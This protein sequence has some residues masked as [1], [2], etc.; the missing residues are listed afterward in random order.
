MT[1]SCIP[2]PEPVSN[3]Y[4]PLFA[5]P[6]HSLGFGVLGLGFRFIGLSKEETGVV[7]PFVLK[8]LLLG[9]FGGFEVE[10]FNGPTPYKGPITLHSQH[11]A[12]EP[13]VVNLSPPKSY[14]LV[15][16]AKSIPKPPTLNVDVMTLRSSSQ[17]PALRTLGFATLN[18]AWG[19][20]VLEM[21]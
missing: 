19:Q 21:V 2:Y 17:S 4:K 1:Y 7:Q 15:L 18:T 16:N 13:K 9:L 14:V 10:S 11:L 3:T 8:K 20:A 5:S 12:I 6:L